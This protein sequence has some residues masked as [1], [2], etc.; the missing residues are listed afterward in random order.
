LNE[1]RGE[2]RFA[3]WVAKFAIHETAAACRLADDGVRSADQAPLTNHVPPAERG[4]T[5]NV[6]L[7]A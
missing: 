4:T 3:T 1:Y 7:I 2:S 6:R 5:R